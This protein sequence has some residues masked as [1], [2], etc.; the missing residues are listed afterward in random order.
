MIL[1]LIK[2]LEIIEEAK[3]I[4]REEEEEYL[5]K[6]NVKEDILFFRRK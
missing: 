4:Q 6:K 5:R 1:F 3:R 2:R